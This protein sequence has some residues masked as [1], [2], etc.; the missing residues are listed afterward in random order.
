MTAPI[1][2][3]AAERYRIVDAAVSTL[4]RLRAGH[5][6]SLGADELRLRV[7]ALYDR[8]LSAV[9]RHD[10]T[11]MLGYAEALANERFEA[12][13]D[14]AEIQTV[15][16]VLEEVI[17]SA[18]FSDLEPYQYATTLGPV[19]M[20]LGAAKDRLADRYVSLAT[21]AHSPSLDLTR[22]CEGTEALVPEPAQ[23]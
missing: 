7:E 21:R 11:V 17:W 8:V 22:L 10:I 4:E 5:Y 18:V 13:Y 20:V 16:N 2:F 12:G 14:L 9:A 3:L 19:T 15:F 1:G 6:E 23:R